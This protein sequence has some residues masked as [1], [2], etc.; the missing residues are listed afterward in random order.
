MAIRTSL[1]KDFRVR[2]DQLVP[3]AES[4]NKNPTDEDA[5]GVNVN[6]R[7]EFVLHH[8]N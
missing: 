3:V 2:P 8:R 4:N 7:V 5:K 1:I 6:R